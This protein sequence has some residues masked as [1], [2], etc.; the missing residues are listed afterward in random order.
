MCT[1]IF[2]ISKLKNYNYFLTY[3]IVVGRDLD[4]VDISFDLQKNLAIRQK[5][6]ISCEKIPKI[7]D[8]L[9]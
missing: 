6:K 1:D 3:L 4:K 9:Y 7:K 8:P 5:G 2:H